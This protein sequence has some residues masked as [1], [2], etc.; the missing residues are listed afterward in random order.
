MRLLEMF[1][2]LF[3]NPLAFCI[4]YLTDFAFQGDRGDFSHFRVHAGRSIFGIKVE[5]TAKRTVT[6][7]I[8]KTAPDPQ[9]SGHRIRWLWAMDC[10]ESL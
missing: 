2:I 1:D 10:L 5:N 8:L 7:P 6:I 4:R 3:D 9:N